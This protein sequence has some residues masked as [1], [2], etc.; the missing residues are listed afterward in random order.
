MKK[1][2]IKYSNT[3]QIY[4]QH[5]QWLLI[6][7]KEELYKHLKDGLTAIVKHI[8]ETQTLHWKQLTKSLDM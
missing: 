4:Q 7:Q 2:F 3:M 1:K 5:Y 8:V 6:F